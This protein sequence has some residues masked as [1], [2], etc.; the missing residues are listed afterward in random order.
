[1]RLFRAVD[2]CTDEA[3]RDRSAG[4]NARDVPTDR[5]VRPD[6]HAGDTGVLGAPRHPRAR[7]AGLRTVQPGGHRRRFSEARPSSGE[8]AFELSLQSFD[9]SAATLEAALYEAATSALATTWRC[10]VPS[11]YRLRQ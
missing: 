2:W 9:N 8:A 10:A 3:E 6:S 4:A 7:A 11:G 1:M 5:R